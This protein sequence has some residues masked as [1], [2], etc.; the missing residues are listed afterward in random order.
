MSL[1]YFLVGM[2]K[3][4]REYIKQSRNFGLMH[5]FYFQKQQ[6]TARSYLFLE[7]AIVQQ[8]QR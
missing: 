7:E 6:N 4:K 2:R 5:L 8:F 3:K 1:K